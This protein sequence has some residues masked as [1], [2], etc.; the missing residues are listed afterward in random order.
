MNINARPVTEDNMLDIVDGFEGFDLNNEA[1]ALM[2]QGD[3]EGSER[4]HL[5]ALDIKERAFGRDGP[6]VATTCDE[7]GIVQYRQ[8][9]YD[10]AEKNLRRAMAIRNRLYFEDKM[11]ADVRDELAR[12]LEAQGKLVEARELRC[13]GADAGSMVVG[14]I[15]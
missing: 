11:A 12:V 5:R 13:S 7:L 1:V 4:L 3:N 9:K 10:E 8:R 14:S 15:M 2:N 6:E